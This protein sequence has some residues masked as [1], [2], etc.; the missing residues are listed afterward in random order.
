MNH[1][2]LLEHDIELFDCL[3]CCHRPCNNHVVVFSITGKAYSLGGSDLR[4]FDEI[5]SHAK[6]VGVIG[7]CDGLS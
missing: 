3:G 7:S 4:K 1:C 2:M 6:A 5:H